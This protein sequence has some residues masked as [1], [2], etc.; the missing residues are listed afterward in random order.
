MMRLICMTFS[1]IQSF[2]FTDHT[3]QLFF[4]C[5][6]TMILEN[7]KQFVLKDVFKASDDRRNSLQWFGNNSSNFVFTFIT[8][9]QYYV[10]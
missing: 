4:K 2:T 7:F 9:I 6:M 8:M 3:E 1:I 5:K 10:L